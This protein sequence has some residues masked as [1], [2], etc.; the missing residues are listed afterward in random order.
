[1]SNNII[2]RK[3]FL[4]LFLI[5]NVIVIG[6]DK[7]VIRGNS[8][9]P[10]NIFITILHIL[11]VFSTL[12]FQTKISRKYTKNEFLISEE[13]GHNFVTFFI[14]T[15]IAFF[16]A[17][18][19]FG[20]PIAMPDFFKY[21]TPI[22]GSII[23]LLIL[24]KNKK[25]LGGRFC[26]EISFNLLIIGLMLVFR[27]YEIFFIG[28]KVIHFTYFYTS[29]VQLNQRKY[30]I[31]LQFILQSAANLLLLSFFYKFNKYAFVL[32]VLTQGAIIFYLI[33]NSRTKNN[34]G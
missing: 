33:I 34:G 3:N 29:K 10:L 15:A 24:I 22:S 31:Y 13:L 18:E 11:L 28:I 8:N 16:L 21:L 26:F 27:G 17:P 2:F 4:I 25:N 7:F 30:S 19:N 9:S 6:L 14:V 1:M 5:H 32:Y 12:Y 23:L 20:V